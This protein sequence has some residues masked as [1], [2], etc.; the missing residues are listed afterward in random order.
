MFNRGKRR[1][2]RSSSSGPGGDHLARPETS[3]RENG[4]SN[5]DAPLEEHIRTR[6]YQLYLERGAA[7]NGD[8]RD[9]LR[10]EREFTKPP[11]AS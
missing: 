6:A 4:V 11:L 7:P 10:A 1:S 2:P 3:Q 9:W 8:V 5:T